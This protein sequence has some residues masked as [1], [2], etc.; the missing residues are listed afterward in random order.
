M[1]FDQVKFGNRLRNLRKQR[2][3]TQ[4]QLAAAVN[5][6]TVHL[7]NIE[8]GKRGLSIDLM[9]ELSNVLNVSLDYLIIGRERTSPQVREF[10]RKAHDIL[11]E[12][13]VLTQN[14]C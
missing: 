7:G 1:Y 14:P 13:D 8:L 11:D 12:L 5:I 4:E 10:I 2:G 6:S 9:I 3:K